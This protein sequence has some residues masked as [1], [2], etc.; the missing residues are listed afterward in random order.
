MPAGRLSPGPRDYETVGE[1][2]ECWRT[3]LQACVQAQGEAALFIGDAA[4]QVDA[5]LA[6]LPGVAAVNDLASALAAL[7]TIVTQGEG[8]GSEHARFA[9]LALRAHGQRTGRAARP[10]IPTS[11][12]PGRPPPTR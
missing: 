8:A 4:L 5:T 2:Y 11:S 6:P 7:A 3:S 10:P 9:F 1:L 12:P